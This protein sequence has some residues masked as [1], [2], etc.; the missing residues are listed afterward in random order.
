[1]D[2]FENRIC[3]PIFKNKALKKYMKE[4]I[5]ILKSNIIEIK[6]I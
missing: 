1:M 4:N 5:G 3:N 6:A 2:I